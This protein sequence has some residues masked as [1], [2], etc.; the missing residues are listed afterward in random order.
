MANNIQIVFSENIGLFTF[1]SISISR[2]ADIVLY[3]KTITKVFVPG[4]LLDAYY[5]PVGATMDQSIDNL[6]L[7]LNTFDLD[8]TIVFTRITNG[9]LMSFNPAGIYIFNVQS[10]I[11]N[12]VVTSVPV[13][14]P[15]NVTIPAIEIESFSIQIIDTYDNDRVLIDEVTLSGSPTLKYDS[16]DDLYQ[17]LMNSELSFNMLASNFQ[18][19]IFLHLLTGDE[20]RYKVKLLSYNAAQVES[21]I[22]QGFLLPDQYNE[23]YKN[24]VLPVEFTAV[25]R[26]GSLKGKYLPVWYY[27]NRFPIAELIAI[28]LQQTGLEQNLVV[29]PSIVPHL[30]E[31]KNINVP[32]SHYDKE[33]KLTDVY[34]ILTDI[35]ESQALTLYSYRGYWWLEGCTRKGERSGVALQFD[36][37]GNSLPDINFIKNVNKYFFATNPTLSAITP[38]KAVNVDFTAEGNDNVFS[39]HIVQKEIFLTVYNEVI[40]TANLSGNAY[41]DGYLRDWTKVGCP[42]LAYRTSDIRKYKE[43]FNF[44]NL[45]INSSA[46]NFI[47]LP[48]TLQN[49]FIAPERPFLKKNIQYEIE[50]E[51]KFIF[52]SSLSEDI[53]SSY[54]QL[55]LF[56][57]L[58]RFQ[59]LMNDIVVFTN[60]PEQYDIKKFVYDRS[61]DTLGDDT[62]LRFRIKSKFRLNISGRIE[63][64]ILHPRT[65]IGNYALPP[66]QSWEWDVLKINVLDDEDTEDIV[67]LERPINYTLEK[68]VSAKFTC[69]QDESIEN[70][71]GIGF[72]TNVFPYTFDIPRN[73]QP[74][75]F[76]D[77]QEFPTGDAVLTLQTFQVEQTILDAIFKNNLRKG[78]FSQNILGVQKSFYKL[79]GRV[80][81]AIFV[82]YTYRMGYLLS[83][84]D[85]PLLPKKYRNID[86]L[87]PLDVLK[88]MFVKY[89]I[90]NFDKRSEWVLIARNYD[91]EVPELPLVQNYA[92]VLGNAV[93]SVQPEVM[94]RL[95]GS[96][97]DLLFPDDL[98]RFRYNNQD[99]IFINTSLTIDLANAETSVVATE[100][101]TQ[102]LTDISYE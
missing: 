81:Y 40:E 36:Y 28:I 11:A 34:T 57:A 68:E 29:K 39:D 87:E 2:S 20:N 16:G 99:K 25:D 90:E 83:F 15:A 41:R 70:S 13:L 96:V 1:W 78:V 79:W 24:G 5:V 89:N 67:R 92:S 58:F 75:I 17:S 19:G 52:K 61:V 27:A 101:K 22:W 102:R 80:K 85:E 71:F 4:T 45:F 43:S 21:L 72:P 98:I 93:I 30:N 82:G 31:W 86:I 97:K 32:L 53:I 64:R 14:L 49:Y 37:A 73:N 7:S 3:Q 10:Q 95:E 54:L 50:I 48:F 62:V 100:R 9:I 26:I 59:L 60:V 69:S 42:A 12:T 88:A 38:W 23:P 35:L 8:G 84:T 46:L 76:T 94:F 47:F 56:D 74:Q 63:F 55:K 51:A 6:L 91:N 65:Q 33:G 66:E 77:L 18:D 44:K